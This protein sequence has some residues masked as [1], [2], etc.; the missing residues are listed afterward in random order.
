MLKNNHACAHMQKGHT[1]KKSYGIRAVVN[2][3]SVCD[4]FSKKK[5][6][7]MWYVSPCL[8]G[9]LIKDKDISWYVG[10]QF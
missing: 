9:T 3:K 6:E 7:Y 1:W 5:K 8:H 2:W 10:V 4:L